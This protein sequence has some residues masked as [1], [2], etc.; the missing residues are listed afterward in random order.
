MEICIRNNVKWKKESTPNEGEGVVKLEPW[1][2]VDRNLK[3][4]PEREE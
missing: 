3:L 2:T 4:F 1:H